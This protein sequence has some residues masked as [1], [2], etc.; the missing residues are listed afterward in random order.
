MEES[1]KPARVADGLLEPHDRFTWTG[2]RVLGE[3]AVLGDAGG[4]VG[5]GDGE[6]EEQGVTGPRDEGE[7]VWVVDGEDVCEG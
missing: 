1:D 3:R 6:N 4:F 5:F 7:E 2:A